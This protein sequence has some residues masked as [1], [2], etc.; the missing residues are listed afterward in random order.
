MSCVGNLESY[1]RIWYP[2]V[3]PSMTQMPLLNKARLVSYVLHACHSKIES[4]V[5]KIKDLIGDEDVTFTDIVE[6]AETIF[7]NAS[8]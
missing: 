2:Q 5:D 6:L 7:F 3:E 4:K 8:A 1:A